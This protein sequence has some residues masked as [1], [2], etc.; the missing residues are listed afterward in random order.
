MILILILILIG[1]QKNEKAKI[2]VTLF[3]QFRANR[4]HIKI[5]NKIIF[6]RMNIFSYIAQPLMFCSHVTE[7]NFSMSDIKKWATSTPK[8]Y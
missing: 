7:N 2:N 3:W 8:T 5:H 1:T 6:K 4:L